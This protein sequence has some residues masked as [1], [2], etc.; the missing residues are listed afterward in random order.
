MN[1]IDILIVIPLVYAG[2]KGFKKG[3]IIEIFTFL[4]FAVGIYAGIHLSDSCATLLKSKFE[5]DSPYLPVISFTLTFLLVGALIFFAGKTVEQMIKVVRLTPF[6]KFLGIFFALVK[7][8]YIVS[9]CIV[10]IE[11]YDEK[12]HFLPLDKKEKSLLY[13][14]VRNVTAY[15]IPGIKESSIFIENAFR[16][17]IDSTGLSAPEIMET[18]KIA[19]S[20]G[21][22]IHNAND[23]KTLHDNYVKTKN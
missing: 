4:A 12:N 17:E 22:E 1:L 7:M 21:L 10:I 23:L 19:D 16:P 6:N 3:F 15:T 14:P 20:L 11:S 2:Y 13:K 18:K 9:V 8:L 5:W